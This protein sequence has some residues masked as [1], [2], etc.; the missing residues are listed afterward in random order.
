MVDT[1]PLIPTPFAVDAAD[2]ADR[3]DIPD[4]D[5]ADGH[6]S[7]ELGFPPVTMLPVLAGGTPPFGQDVNG[8]LYVLS[9][10]AQARQA[11][12]LPFWGADIEASIGGYAKG[13]LV[14][15]DD[16]TQV[17]FNG[18][19]DNSADPTDAASGWSPFPLFS[20]K[21]PV[22]SA[23]TALSIG[24]YAKGT[25]LSITDGSGVW[26]NTLANN[27]TEPSVSGS[28]WLPLVAE[29]LIGKLPVFSASSSLTMGGYPI[30][31]I[32]STGGGTGIW[33][34]TIAGNT[35]SPTSGTSSGWIPLFSSAQTNIGGLTGGTLTLST[36]QAFNALLRLNGTLTSNLSVVVP[37]YTYRQLRVVNG[38]AGAF[39]VTVKTALGA[40]VVIAANTLATSARIF[41]AET[42]GSY[43]VYPG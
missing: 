12:Q 6:A 28:G 26:F 14:I 31:T 35:A 9:W 7:Y 15:S 22:F 23:G 17:R 21:L 40:G 8:I 4:V 37:D 32:L 34:N 29:Q 11:G 10:H 2:P 1:P 16:G 39:T 41:V 18:T 20:G 30:G 42:S 25:L 5:A 43:E 19:A 24:G 38:C 3:V 13:A 27:S 33:F 36:A